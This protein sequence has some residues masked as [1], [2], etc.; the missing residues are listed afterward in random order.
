MYFTDDSLFPENQAP[1]MITAAPYGPMWLPG[2]ISGIESEGHA[3]ELPRIPHAFLITFSAAPNCR[4]ATTCVRDFLANA[5]WSFAKAFT[6]RPFS[7][8][9]FSLSVSNFQP[10]PHS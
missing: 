2:G 1:L 9:D 10:I 6:V 4:L 3:P 7:Y 8:N 5:D